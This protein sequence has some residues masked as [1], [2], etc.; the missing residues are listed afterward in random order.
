MQRFDFRLQA[1]LR[2]RAFHEERCRSD[3]G[4]LMVQ[5][6][7]VQAQIAAVE[8][9]IAA[10]YVEQEAG[11]QRGMRASHLSD[12]PTKAA[13]W[14]TH[15]QQLHRDLERIDGVVEAKRQELSQRR[16]DLKLLEN[17]RE[18]DLRAW[19]KAYDKNET[20]KV[21]EMVQ[22]WAEAQGTSSEEP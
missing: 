14:Q 3:L 12:Y 4:R 2:M 21:D 13:G 11:L 22:L 19:K 6:Q 18:K 17:L 8:S 9:A 20:L 5:R 1:L 16:A 15:L 10:S 7:D